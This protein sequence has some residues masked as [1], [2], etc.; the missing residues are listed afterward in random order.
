MMRNK[1]YRDD[2]VKNPP[3]DWKTNPGLGNYGKM[4][5]LLLCS[6]FAIVAVYRLCVLT[7]DDDPANAKQASSFHAQAKAAKRESLKD[8]KEFQFQRPDPKQDYDLAS[9]L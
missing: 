4:P 2:L 8:F 7:N 6:P 1:S 3:T 9:G 5:L